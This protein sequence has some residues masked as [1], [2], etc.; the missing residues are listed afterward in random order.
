MKKIINSLVIA[1]VSLIVISDVNAIERGKRKRVTRAQSATMRPPR[2]R[3]ATPTMTKEEIRQQIS[4][5]NK[6]MTDPNL[7]LEEK[8]QEVDKA[9]QAIMQNPETKDLAD[10]QAQ[11]KAKDAEVKAKDEYIKTMPGRGIFYDA[12]AVRDE[13]AKLAQLKNELADLKKQEI[14]QSGVV[15]SQMGQGTSKLV[16]S[17]VGAG[18]AVGLAAAAYAAYTYDMLPALPGSGQ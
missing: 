1:A 4:S 14:A 17:V 18:V 3:K 2:P 8:Q 9:K 6:N 5:A 13:K 11:I 15:D 10:L 7:P 12:Q 16:K